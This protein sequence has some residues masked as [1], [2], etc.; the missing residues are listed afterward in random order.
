MSNLDGLIE[1]IA[2]GDEAALCSLYHE[3]CSA[4]YGFALS[5][6]RNRAD[7]EDVMQDTYLQIMK[8]AS[9]YAARGKP[10]SWVLTVARNLA[11]MKLRSGKHAAGT[12]ALDDAIV[13]GDAPGLDRE[14]ALVL[15][16][17]MRALDDD[18]RQIVVLHAISGF[19]HRE[20]ASLL[21]LKLSTVLSKYQR[22]LRKLRRVLEEGE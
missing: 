17:A 2:A 7:A 16:A 6:V 5:I 10:L 20:T 21:N 9:T 18:E 19:K 13:P 4:V 14:D 22:A 12:L 11:L 3:T 8:S 15:G 1:R